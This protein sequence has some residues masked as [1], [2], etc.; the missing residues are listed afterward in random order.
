M[1]EQADALA[2]HLADVHHGQVAQLRT[3]ALLGLEDSAPA[4]LPRP[5]PA[6]VEIPEP[7]RRRRRAEDLIVVLLG[8]SVGLGLGRLLGGLVADA[9]DTGVPGLRWIGMP[10]MLVVGL[11]IAIWVI[12]VRRASAAR[13]ATQTWTEQALAAVRT[14]LER[15]LTDRT[16]AADAALTSRLNRLT[17]R[18]DRR[19]AG[20]LAEIDNA[21]RAVLARSE[22]AP[23]TR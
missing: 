3:T 11:V 19:I 21:A 6:R 7:P 2:I 5:A 10:V 22:R 18:Q 9:A 4:G 16:N 1:R 15:D 8:I 14:G 12:R 13:A 23:P 20:Q 17:A